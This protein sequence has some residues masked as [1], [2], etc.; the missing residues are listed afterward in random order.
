MFKILNTTSWYYLKYISDSDKKMFEILH[1]SSWRHDDICLASPDLVVVP[2]EIF[3]C[4][5]IL[6]GYFPRRRRILRWIAWEPAHWLPTTPKVVISNGPD[7]RSLRSST[8]RWV[9]R[10][11]FILVV[12]SFPVVV[13]PFARLP[14]LVLSLA[15]YLTTA[16][17]LLRTNTHLVPDPHLLVHILLPDTEH[18]VTCFNV[19]LCIWQ[20]QG[21]V[22][23]KSEVNDSSR[24]SFG[25]PQLF[26][27]LL[28]EF[29]H[30]AYATLLKVDDRCLRAV[31]GKRGGFYMPLHCVTSSILHI[32][33]M[34]FS[35]A[36]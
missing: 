12:G 3:A 11:P 36:S 34:K 20:D 21:E 17:T 9:T 33:N 14:L 2:W 1:R 30:F 25:S 18:L 26:L 35:P 4:W 27:H 15:S 7:D 24:C 22:N 5:D 10:N 6:Y 28:S 31:R 19:K 8:L 16:Y 13:I 32:S 29:I 23:V